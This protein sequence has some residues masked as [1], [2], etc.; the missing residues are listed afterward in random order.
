MILIKNAHIKPITSPDIPGGSI[1]IRD[2]KILD[3]GLE[4]PGA[5]ARV[6]DAAGCMVTPGFIDGHCHI[7]I[8]NDGAGEETKDA[9]EKADPITPQMRAI[10]GLNPDNR[11]FSDALAGGVTSAATG[12]GSS[13]VVGGTFAAIKLLGMRID[14]MVIKE[15]VAMK[16]AFGQNPKAL[17]GSQ[18]KSPFTRMAIAAMLRETLR[19]AFD[20]K[21]QI[22]DAGEDKTKLPKYD[23]KMEALLPVV[24]RE[25]PLKA[26]AHEADDIFTAIRIAK[27]FGLPMTL[28]HCTEGH[29]IADELAEEGYPCFVGPALVGRSKYE[30]RNVSFDTAS[31]LVRAGVKVA[32]VTDS[33][34]VP[35]QYLPVSAG[36]AVRAGLDTE[37]AFRAI[38]IHPAEMLGIQDRVGSL[39]KGKDADIAVFTGNPVT[40]LDCRTM[41]TLVDGK[42]AYRADNFAP[43]LEN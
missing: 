22:D 26:H 35:L 29:L 23:A 18:K 1:L 9:N 34:I 42:I 30:L 10:D 19:K 8:M 21:Q 28:D 7:G 16:I 20:Y 40:Q 43:E 12:P 27:E 15:P 3:I 38:T 31:V 14:K 24:R 17:Y 5:D 25:I 4:F 33:N 37:Y 13:N 41:L 11:S 32:I 2:G 36:L 39:E 6:V